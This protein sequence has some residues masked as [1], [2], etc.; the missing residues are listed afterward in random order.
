MD[1]LE[2][3]IR[4]QKR[5]VGLSVT[6]SPTQ[7][8]FEAREEREA[9]AL[10]AQ[11]AQYQNRVRRKSIHL[12]VAAAAGEQYRDT[13]LATRDGKY[14]PKI[15]PAKPLY[16]RSFEN[17][18]TSSLTS[19]E[20][21]ARK[22]KKW[23]NRERDIK[24]AGRPDEDFYVFDSSENSSD[25]PD[26]GPGYRP[27]KRRGPPPGSRRGRG[28][29]NRPIDWSTDSESYAPSSDALGDD[30]SS[31]SSVHSS[32]DVP[33]ASDS[34][35]DGNIPPAAVRVARAMMAQAEAAPGTG[36][37][38]DKI[39]RR[40]LEKYSKLSAQ[41]LNELDGKGLSLVFNQATQRRGN[42][43]AGPDANLYDP[44]RWKPF[45][46]ADMSWVK[47]E[48]QKFRQVQDL[49]TSGWLTWDQMEKRAPELGK[50]LHLREV[51][52][53]ELWDPDVRVVQEG[54]MA[55]GER[56]RLGIDVITKLSLE[57]GRTPN[58]LEPYI[59]INEYDPVPMQLPDKLPKEY[60]TR[61]LPAPRKLPL[62]GPSGQVPAVETR[63]TATAKGPVGTDKPSKEDPV[64]VNDAVTAAAQF[65]YP[66]NTPTQSTFKFAD[67][68]SVA[69]IFDTPVVG[70]P[71]RRT[72]ELQELGKELVKREAKVR[73]PYM[74]D[75]QS[76]PT[77][78]STKLSFASL[79]ERRGASLEPYPP[80]LSE[81]PRGKKRAAS[82]DNADQLS[83]GNA[84]KKPRNDNNTNNGGGGGNAGAK[85]ENAS[86]AKKAI[87]AR[88][89]L[90]H[91]RIRAILEDEEEL[92][93]EQS[94]VIEEYRVST[95]KA[96]LL[97]RAAHA[98]RSP[99][100]SSISP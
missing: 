27:P 100:A 25:G 68:K 33:W 98:P 57:K 43:P 46:S 34:D 54:A 13:T 20:A 38:V 63:Q 14:I 39:S 62:M 5:A 52:P 8:E 32:I 51:K 69:D 77:P 2:R 92:Q 29:Q 76:T 82:A 45:Q 86:I 72:T 65:Q 99:L 84:G 64:V 49:E 26:P 96:S 50:V 56:P 60:Q 66:L 16:Y 19:T 89:R 18:R 31:N 42:Q 95:T 23:L 85:N 4:A 59:W 79:S 53:D 3:Q 93:T 17:R 71:I 55:S 6:P 35:D 94:E 48:T 1:E 75:N 61:G 21:T 78:F 12:L 83:Q 22:I 80:R 88:N 73:K 15:D 91:P 28:P 9:A 24:M 30:Y 97:H 37:W 58:S 74:F 47:A 36:D 81:A 87:A 90:P 40:L 44:R 7:S 10:E 67:G 70:G 41:E 11:I